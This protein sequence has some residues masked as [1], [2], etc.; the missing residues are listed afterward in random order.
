MSLSKGWNPSPKSIRAERDGR[1][2][3]ARRQLAFEPLEK[4]QLLATQIFTVSVA[5]DNGDNA[6]PT[7]G[8]LRAAIVAANAVVAGDDAV[9]D[10]SISGA[11][12]HVLGIDS[13]YELP[14]IVKPTVVDGYSQGG[15]SY[16][17][18]PLIQIS[19]GSGQNG[20]RLGVGADGS[21]IKGLSIVNFARSGSDGGAGIWI[22]DG[23][24]NVTV[25]GNYIGLEADGTTGAG[26]TLGVLVQGHS[27]TIGGTVAG[28]GNVIAGNGQGG[29]LVLVD[30]TGPN[31]SVSSTIIAGNF[32]GTNA[33]G[34]AIVS[35]GGA[36]TSGAP[37]YKSGFNIGLS[38]TTATAI[39]GNLVSGSGGSGIVLTTR[40]A[41]IAG[42][43]TAIAGLVATTTTTIKGNLIGTNAAG[44]ASLSNQTGILIA[45]ADHVT[46]GGATLADR[47]VISG[48]QGF[49]GPLDGGDGILITGN[50]DFITIQGNYIGVNAVG[51]AALGNS[52]DGIETLYTD[53]SGTVLPTTVAGTPTNLMI[54]GSAAGDGNLISAN[55][56]YG[57]K[58]VGQSYATPA[59]GYLIQ[60]N[61][62]GAFADGTGSNHTSG[63]MIRGIYLKHTSGA[64]VRGNSL[65]FNDFGG[66]EAISTLSTTVG[67]LTAG[68]GNVIAGLS[69]V[70]IVIDGTPT[71][72][73]QNF[74]IQNNR[75]GMRLDETFANALGAGNSGISARLIDGLEVLGNLVVKTANGGITILDSIG[76]TV[77]SNTIAG[78]ATTGLALSGAGAAG[79]ID[80]IQGNLIGTMQA[81]FF[82][83]GEGNGGDGI[84]VPFASASDLRI[85]GNVVAQSGGH[86]INLLGAASVTI[87]GNTVASSGGDGIRAIGLRGIDD[88][89]IGNYFHDS[90]GSGISVAP[91]TGALTIDAN[92][93]RQS[94]IHGI[95][96][97]SSGVQIGTT[98][99][100]VIVG[101]GGDGVHIE[102]NSGLLAGVRIARNRIGILADG[103]LEANLGS[104]INAIQTSGLQVQ[105]NVI[106]GNLG[107]G[108]RVSASQA[109]TIGGPA[110]G[111][112]N[113]IAGNQLRGIDVQGNSGVISANNL[114]QGNA[115]GT[116][117][118][119]V[120]AGNGDDGIR[121]THASG[122]NVLGNSVAHGGKQG[123]RVEDSSQVTIGGPNVGDGNVVY[124]NTRNGISVIGDSS[125]RI[126]D[127]LIQANKVGV[128]A[129]DT[130]S[131]GTT[132]NGDD[133]IDVQYATTL[134]IKGN[135][136]AYNGDDGMDL[137][138]PV[139]AIIGGLLP[140]DANV[141]FANVK[142][143]I[144]LSGGDVNKA[145]DVTIQGNLIGVL[146]DRTGSLEFTGN[147]DDGIDIED[148]INVEIL[149]NLIAY[150]GDDGI[151]IDDS[152]DLSIL[153][154]TVAGN[155]DDGINLC[156]V[157][158]AFVG[159]SYPGDGNL[160]TTNGGDGIEVAGNWGVEPPG[161]GSSG[162]FDPGIVIRGN[163]IG[164]RA[165]G[166]GD[167]G[168]TGNQGK[169]IYA[170]E[171]AGLIVAGNKVAYNQAGVFVQDSTLTTVGG[172][173]A[174]DGNIIFANRGE[175]VALDNAG[176]EVS[177]GN[178]VRNN[179]IG[180]F[181]NGTGASSGMISEISGNSGDG[182]FASNNDGLTIRGNVVR[183]NADDGIEVVGSS[184]TTIGGP[185]LGDGNVIASNDFD[186]IKV[187]GEFPDPAVGIL[188]QNNAIGVLADGSGTLMT[189][190]NGRHGVELFK[191]T[192]AQV[193]GNI[194]EY[195]GRPRITMSSIEI[196]AM[197]G[198]DGIHAELAEAMTISGNTILHNKFAGIKVLDAYN[199]TIGG[200]NDGE[201]NVV[202]NNEGG[203]IFVALI[204]SG[205]TN[206]KVLGNKVGVLADGSAAGND[207]TGISVQ[208]AENVEILGNVSEFNTG[209][210]VEVSQ[211]TSLTLANNVVASNRGDGVALYT[212]A[213]QNQLF[214]NFIGEL[215]NG[216]AAG[217]GQH[218]VR[219][220][221][222]SN[223]DL[224]HNAIEYNGAANHQ[225]GSINVTSG[226]GHGISAYNS[227]DLT[228]RANTIAHNDFGGI[229]AA[230]SL[231]LTIGGLSPADGN[232]I[233][234]N[235]QSGIGVFADGGVSSDILIRNNKVGLFADG[236]AGGNGLDGIRAAGSVNVT[237]AGNAVAHNG[238]DGLVALGLT[239]SIVGG[240]NAG[241]GNV[242][243]KNAGD[244]IHALLG[245]SNLSILGNSIGVVADGTGSAATTGNGRNGIEV[246]TS[247]GVS[248]LGNMVRY[249]ALSG[250]NLKYTQNSVVRS[251]QVL[252][253]LGDGISDLGYHDTIGGAMDGAANLIANNG[254]A[255]VSVLATPPPAPAASGGI[256]ISAPVNYGRSV[257]ISRNSIYG[258]AG[259]GITLGGST[260]PLPNGS[261]PSGPNQSQ[262]YPVDVT[263]T[264]SPDTLSIAG[265]LVGAPSSDYI[266][267][268]FSNPTNDASGHGQGRTF[269]GSMS[270][271][272]DVAGNATFTLP[273][274]M[275]MAPGTI[276]SSTATDSLDNT[277]EFSL[278]A[279]ALKLTQVSMLPQ[280]GPAIAGQAFVLSAQV[281]SPF[282]GFGGTVTFRYGDLIIGTA[283]VAADGTATYTGVAPAAGAYAITATYNPSELFA[284]ATSTPQDQQVITAASATSLATS[285]SPSAVGQAVT[286]TAT[287][288]GQG[289]P[290]GTVAFMEGETILGYGEISPD[291]V[292]TFTTSSLARGPHS[293]MAVFQGS[294]FFAVSS[295]P[296]IN[297]SVFGQTATNLVA[298]PG[299]VAGNQPVTLS[300][301][302]TTSTGSVSGTVLFYDGSTL[303]GSGAV[304]ANG[305]ATL[306]T[307]SLAV[308]THTITA[309]FQGAADFLINTSSTANLVVTQ[310]ATEG[311]QVVSS[312]PQSFY[313][314]DV[315]LTATFEATALGQTPMTGTVSFYDGS[316]FL[317][318]ATL[319]P[320]G[321]SGLSV[322]ASIASG[323]ASLPTTTLSVGGHVIRALYSGDATY[324]PS[325]SE[326]PVTVLVIQATTG[327][328]LSASSNAQGATIL[329]AAVTA[330]SPGTPTLDGTVSFYE[331]DT[332][333][334]TSTVVNG[335]ATLNIGALSAG[336]HGFRA[337]FSGG[338]NASSSAAVLAFVADGP[339]V[340]GLSRYGFHATPTTLSL[341]FSGPLNVASAQNVA[342]YRITDGR[343]K[344]VAIRSA[345]Y[346]AATQT[347][348]L[349][350]ARR[351][352][353]HKVYTLTVLGTGST[354]LT[355]ADGLAL[356]G[357]G[358]G[359]PGSNFVAPISWRT[360]TTRNSPPAVT[361]VKGQAKATTGSFGPYVN[362]VV[363]ATKAAMQAATARLAVKQIALARRGK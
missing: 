262:N 32:L 112:G 14:A 279:T 50:A 64:S 144:E 302:V 173:T 219:L 145:S 62:I 28:Q 11:G 225:L 267:E 71:E 221:T 16:A 29:I 107:N 319:I 291:G 227:T 172:E 114:I 56:W 320:T 363:R 116:L 42:S 151:D 257:L 153:G 51:Q 339:Q 199:L 272:T 20:L 246:E 55:G 289:S 123:I 126:A 318:T 13:T 261:S 274:A 212:I 351:L 41:D 61:N 9:I 46:I 190:G 308:G 214:G 27:A 74:A 244:G 186:G 348:T 222:V 352:D 140:S 142:N 57:V 357:V 21:T 273:M 293:I 84:S 155:A 247:S 260:T 184:Q 198:G 130:G 98:L 178:V 204:E 330:T 124:G 295:S 324:S 280:T 254:G 170:H 306:V 122:L 292:A 202:S 271:T 43:F 237:I 360:L 294:G 117:P 120:A 185:G 203:G 361:Y 253:N 340:V 201:G 210:G 102:T 5:T 103:T 77:D 285:V 7:T 282:A 240:A 97:R 359:T 59:T 69:G 80:L 182:I 138:H 17:G 66:I 313:G 30:G 314:Q 19:G 75:I 150:N 35:N 238:G 160:I 297:Q 323:Q 344:P 317:G 226:G 54:G 258:N 40:P 256:V 24:T 277:S 187:S 269:L 39:E 159:G 183:Y 316:T 304:D 169:G 52:G 88:Q 157:E 334:G 167:R 350:P 12:T 115:I 217:N 23:V 346:D 287:V 180:L 135:V 343:G 177:H 141:V 283:T 265:M 37:G 15:G 31:A 139:G 239:S 299:T 243:V 176:A 26:N 242:V 195:S 4:L 305:V 232:V 174:H 128:L 266:L 196:Q 146:G 121:V 132:G 215:A 268:F 336:A 223:L 354:H 347:V 96:V 335:V 60:G 338:G 25:Q 281:A 95:D 241:D 63:N 362:A 192:D 161:L 235:G 278:N 311:G 191:T 65:L 104:G 249:S 356:D 298:S 45:G 181:V 166:S 251:N 118:G 230:N 309:V 148:T 131:L 125:D 158:G 119:D 72:H 252:S 228:I 68:D 127:I 248:I 194:I 349:T 156:L 175:G 33:A 53:G 109:T 259:L 332:L 179:T 101:N 44:T 1:V 34:T 171:L 91:V 76:I 149:G 353:I 325:T 49:G 165:D 250:I 310:V 93:I 168:N 99:G 87:T 233:A 94:S 216:T 89:I 6:S 208:N 205:S 111:A 358:N 73:N 85:L 275:T 108:V 211:V 200:A 100:N 152:V 129:D 136:V 134:T 3:R 137:D 255:G 312:T 58:L 229:D 47:N 220:D 83:A 333:L 10:F 300:A 164:V 342:N 341:T 133:G 286:F 79:S 2:K 82:I 329:S 322:S 307:S 110:V 284:E 331:G 143:G 197:N 290:T 315:T 188:I 337:V 328:T 38:G 321:I 113:V 18:A 105:G 288:T 207:A 276:V 213:G 163:S 48:N 36:T 327:T 193:L 303:I 22:E 189:T 326:T 8:S 236:T 70:G 301:T 218:G 92:T 67:G 106:G 154:N 90:G 355:G 86:G 224:H 147:G 206:I 263:A 245:S 81:G 209:T 234:G 296:I 78:N 162:G 345:T 231:R 264:V 270:V